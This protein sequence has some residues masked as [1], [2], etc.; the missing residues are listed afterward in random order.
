MSGPDLSFIAKRIRLLA[1]DVD[2]VLTDNR[3]YQGAGFDGKAF[4]VH[5]KTGIRLCQD[6]LGIPVAL[7][8]GRASPATLAFAEEMNITGCIVAPD[9]KKLEPFEEYLR[10]HRIEWHEVAYVGDDIAD[11]PLLRRCGLPI[12]VKNSHKSV[13]PHAKYVTTTEGGS[14]AVREV[15]DWIAESQGSYAIAYDYEIET[16]ESRV[17]TTAADILFPGII[18]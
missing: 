4:H 7:C 5:D 2:G 13:L 11:V 15:I 14:G 6:R 17:M 8:T 10:Y 16:R 12:A 18:R 9:G 3:N 1:L